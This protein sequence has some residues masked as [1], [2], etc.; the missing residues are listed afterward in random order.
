MSNILE[1]VDKTGRNTILTKERWSHIT[2]PAS[3]HAYIANYLEEIRQALI[4]PDK[5]ISSLY[6]EKKANY[7]KYFKHR[8]SKNKFLRVIVKYLNNHGLIISAYF[9]TNIK[10]KEE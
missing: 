4:K 7:Y 5:I 6:D 2:E 9:I 8:D 10:W 3:P 1:I